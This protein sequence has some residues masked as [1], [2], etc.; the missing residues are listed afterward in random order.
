[1][2]FLAVVHSPD[3]GQE[4]ASVRDKVRSIVIYPRSWRHRPEAVVL[5]TAESTFEAGL[6]AMKLGPEEMR[7]LTIK[8]GGVLTVLRRRLS[9]NRV[10]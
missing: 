6:K 8:T 4:L 10:M 2:D 3:V 1:M 5:E 7:A 9:P